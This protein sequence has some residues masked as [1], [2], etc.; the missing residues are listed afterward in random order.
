MEKRTIFPHKLLPYILLLPQLVI[1]VLFFY[2]PA[3]QAV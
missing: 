2:W 3:S 1:T